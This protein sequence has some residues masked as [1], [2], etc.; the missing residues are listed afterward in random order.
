MSEDLSKHKQLHS[1]LKNLWELIKNKLHSVFD[2]G[3]KFSLRKLADQLS[4]LQ[5]ILVSLLVISVVLFIFFVAYLELSK[6]GIIIEPLE[7]PEALRKSG[8]T[9]RA[10]AN[11]LMDKLN[12]IKIKSERETGLPIFVPV[13][14]LEGQSI[15]VSG[16]G[17]SPKSILEYAKEL[18]GF[19]QNYI[20]G[21]VILEGNSLKLTVRISGEF[22]N[23]YTGQWDTDSKFDTLNSI[24]LQSAKDIYKSTHP[25][26]LSHFYQSV[27]DTKNAVEVLKYSLIHDP[28]EDDKDAYNLW[29]YILYD[30]GVF[31]E[32]IEKFQESIKLEPNNNYG[33]IGLGATFSKQKRYDQAI[34]FFKKSIS[35]RGENLKITYVAWGNMYM[36]QGKYDEAIAKYKEALKLDN[37][38][39]EA[40]TNWGVVLHQQGKCDDAIA[41]YQKAIEFNPKLA[42]VYSCWADVLNENK[43][44]EKAIR[45]LETSIAIDPKNRHVYEVWS[46][47]LSKQKKYTEA[48]S[49]LKKLIELD[50]KS[51]WAYQKWGV[52]LFEQG[53]TDKAIPMFR[54][55]IELDPKNASG[56]F[57]LG[58]IFLEQKKYEEAI[59]NFKR[60]NE[61]DS[62]GEIGEQARYFIR[63]IE[64]RR[65]GNE[66]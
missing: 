63:G 30:N 12:Y 47:I 65:S 10:I 16:V 2:S 29:G 59:F 51:R 41:K 31:D 35:L 32:A 27:G 52:L 60:A 57:R 42:F 50:P 34:T 19:H 40:Y 44:Y 18:M 28:I 25:I 49:K 54:K 36:E 4:F 9:E 11:K 13:S 22:E 17:F 8:Y 7:V 39:H 26:T 58:F 45:K 1:Y 33:Y 66:N 56:Y 23:T 53:G 5:R 61:F 3:S 48:V 6:K 62:E 55:A 64:R 43:E 20:E 21:E 46:D 15:S 24:L 38:Y 37:K 14:R